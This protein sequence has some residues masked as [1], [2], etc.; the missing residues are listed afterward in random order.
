MTVAT[1][2]AGDA[3]AANRGQ[4]GKG[5]PRIAVDASLSQRLDED[6]VRPPH[7]VQTFLGDL[8]KNAHREARP[9]ERMAQANLIG[10]SEKPC[11]IAYLVLEQGSE[12]LEQLKSKLRRK[13][14]HVVVALDV[15]CPLAAG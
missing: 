1:L 12:W 11:H 5:L 7:D 8:A 10:Q 15:R 4:H 9:R 3:H 14:P 13:P 6:R 2:I